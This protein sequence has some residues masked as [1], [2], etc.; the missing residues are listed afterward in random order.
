MKKLAACDYEDLLQ[1]STP[2]ARSVRFL[3]VSAV[4]NTCF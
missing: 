2:G 4:R 1:V 3:T